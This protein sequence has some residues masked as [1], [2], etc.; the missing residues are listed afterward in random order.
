MTG[1]VFFS[2]QSDLPETR[3]TIFWAL[4]WAVRDLD[5]RGTLDEALRV[6]QDTDKVAGW[7]DI[8]ATILEKI[9][10]CELFVADL[11]PING[12]DPEARLTPNPNVMLELGY[13]L[14]HRHGTDPHRL[15]SER[16]IL[17]RGRPLATPIRRA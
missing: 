6:D 16:R 13:A 5:R 7:P 17:A 3:S 15:Y 1:T 10:G 9:E 11:T 2:W 12:P 4:E 14:A 8:A